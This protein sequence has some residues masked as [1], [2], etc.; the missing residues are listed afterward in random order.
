[1]TNSCT[2]RAAMRA[3]D[4]LRAVAVACACTHPSDPAAVRASVA[5]PS[6]RPAFALAPP[7]RGAAASRW[8]TQLARVCAAPSCPGWRVRGTVGPVRPVQ[9]VWP[10]LCRM[11]AASERGQVILERWARAVGIEHSA[12]GVGAAE[13][14]PRGALA[15]DD[16]AEGEV[17]ESERSERAAFQCLYSGI[18]GVVTLLKI[19]LCAGGS[20]PLL[21]P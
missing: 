16:I 4:L 10:A 9:P 12:W 18:I 14:G 17:P 1:M 11:T 6:R 19:P 2:M 21:L 15:R 7:L 8:Q 3:I 5:S 13:G 20:A